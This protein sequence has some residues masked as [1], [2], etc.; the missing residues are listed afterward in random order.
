MSRTHFQIVM[1]RRSN[2]EQQRIYTNVDFDCPPGHQ[3]S[4][5]HGLRQ[6]IKLVRHTR[7]QLPR[8]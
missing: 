8:M 1:L 4:A 7:G 5:G 3:C 6:H 2:L